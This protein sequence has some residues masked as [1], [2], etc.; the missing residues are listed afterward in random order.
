M[1]AEPQITD[2]SAFENGSLG[3]QVVLSIVTFGL[4][5]LYWTYKTAQQLDQGTNRDLTPILGAIPL[6]NIISFWQISD[7]AEAVTDQSQIVLF[8]L[9]LVL[10]PLSWF[11][12][13]SGI[14]DVA[15]N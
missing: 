14:N 9:F 12:I 4:Y 11:W 7:A 1:S 13:Q 8:V 5:S 6:A 2:A 3:L 10:A 15:T